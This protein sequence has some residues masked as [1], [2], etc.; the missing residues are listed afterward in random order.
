MPRDF[1]DLGII[2]KTQDYKEADKIVTILTKKSGLLVAFAVGVR[3]PKSKK[4]PHLDLVNHCQF[5]FKNNGVNFLNEVAPVSDFKNI[6]KDLRK[7]SLCMTFFEIIT[8]LVPE[9]VEDENLYLSLLNFLDQLSLINDNL[10]QNKLCAQ[11]AKYILRHLGYQDNLPTGAQ[12]L[13]KHFEVLMNKKLF[14]KEIV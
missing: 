4:A 9:E 11:F 7:V 14:A 6:K 1:K 13:S 2:L 3:R 12:S 8:Q 10:E 5:Q